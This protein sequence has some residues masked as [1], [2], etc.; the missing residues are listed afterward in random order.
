M[1]DVAE[2]LGCK[3]NH[4]SQIEKGLTNP[5]LEFLKKCIEA[6]E[7]PEIEKADFIAQ[8]FASS[9]Q[10]ALK[11]DNVTIIPKEDLAKL[12]AVLVFNLK[13][14]Y[15]DTEEWGAVI[16]GIKRL[17]VAINSRN[18]AFTTLDADCE[19]NNHH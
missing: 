5:S 4:I 19:L 15:P 16:Y 9:S 3:Q 17:K 13:E 11:M 2:K 7:I 18:P 8:A 12:M 10:L 1:T 6:Y 14:P